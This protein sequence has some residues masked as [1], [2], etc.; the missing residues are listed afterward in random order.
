MKRNG[1]TLADTLDVATTLVFGGAY[2]A[3]NFG[4][5]YLSERARELVPKTVTRTYQKW[6]RK[7]TVF[8]YRL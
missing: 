8:D 7:P 6:R 1:K 5:E 3:R 4:A 2:L